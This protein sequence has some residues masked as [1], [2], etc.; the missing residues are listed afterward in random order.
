MPLLQCLRADS[1]WATISSQKFE[2]AGEFGKLCVQ[3]QKK[4]S[5]MIATSDLLP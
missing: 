2:P 5:D 1:E 4:G 3:G